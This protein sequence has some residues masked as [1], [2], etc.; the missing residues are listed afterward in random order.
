MDELNFTSARSRMVRYLRHDI[1]DEHVLHAMGHIP[2]ER[3]VPSAYQ[4]EAYENKP[5]PIGLE[6]TISQP[7]IVAMMTEA[8]ELR[9]SERVLEIGT[10]SGYQAAILAELASSVITVERHPELIEKAR[11]VLQELGYDNI[12]IHT[13]GRTLG[14]GI[15]A[16][17]DAIV[18]TA[19]APQVPLALLDQ[20]EIGG[21]LVIPVGSRFDQDLLKIIKR[22]K[23]ILTF[24][25]GP[26]RFVPL[27]GEEAW[28]EQNNWN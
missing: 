5:I 17:Y 11:K 8:L 18:V 23:R 10:G 26:C 15:K 16:P 14:W 24:N 21:R 20:L 6:Q 12:E 3:F 9:G 27:V 19:G 28:L 4:H 13:T 1:A 22:E 25:L 7:L 2:R